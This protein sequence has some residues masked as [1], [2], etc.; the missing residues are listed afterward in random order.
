MIPWCV[1]ATLYVM[2]LLVGGLT[3][4]APPPLS[5]GLQAACD[6]CGSPFCPTRH[7]SSCALQ[8]V[9]PWADQPKR[10]AQPQ[11]GA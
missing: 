8:G 3:A 5:Q 11:V 7:C 2:P 9:C 10:Q 4:C 1:Y 6:D